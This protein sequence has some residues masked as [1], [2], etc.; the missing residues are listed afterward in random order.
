MEIT[1]PNNNMSSQ[2]EV[3]VIPAV[4][5]Q[6][7]TN[8]QPNLSTESIPPVRVNANKSNGFSILG[9]TR[10]RKIINIC[11]MCIVILV[12][13]WSSGGLD[14]LKKKYEIYGTSFFAVIMVDD[15][16]SSSEI[17]NQARLAL[18]LDK[19]IINESS[20]VGQLYILGKSNKSTF[21]TLFNNNSDNY[22]A[23]T[24]LEQNSLGTVSGSDGTFFKNNSGGSGNINTNSFATITAY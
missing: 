20:P 9:K 18:K 23:I 16:M 11:L 15:S 24:F 13:I 12:I 10:G 22:Q 5:S 17:E 21:I 3:P 2:Q 8:S 4:N 1:N 19:R 14:F 6:E 7:A